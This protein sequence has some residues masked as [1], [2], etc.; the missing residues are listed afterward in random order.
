MPKPK[1]LSLSQAANELAQQRKSEQAQA[2]LKTLKTKLSASEKDVKSLTRRLELFDRLKAN[3]PSAKW[4]SQKRKKDGEATAIFALSDLHVE[5]SVRPER[6]SGLNE[7]TLDIA[8][9]RLQNVFHRTLMLIED[10][11]HLAALDRLVLWLGGDIIHGSLRD[12]AIAENA[13]HPM[14]ACRWACD[15]LEA[16]IRQLIADAG[17]KQILVA[18]SFGNHG[19]STIKMPSSTAA[20]TSYEHNMYLELSRRFKPNELTWQ[21]SEGYFNF[22]NVYDFPVRFHHGD[23]I[24]FGGGINGVGVPAY[25]SIAKANETKRAYLD[26]FGHFH[27]FGWP[28]R[29]VSNG[30]LVGIDEYSQGFG[31]DS[32]PKQAFIVIDRNRGITRAL[33][34]FAK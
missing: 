16:G 15:R 32:E 3:S 25:R 14:E 26:V 1:A 6:V 5:Q 21:I 20:Q 24:K 33:P 28:G 2:D 29:F 22:V 7:Y 11:R 12:E 34:V 23:R 8:E 9:Q 19:R 17:M 4:A 27:T 18:T 30:S 31:G 10:A 13:L